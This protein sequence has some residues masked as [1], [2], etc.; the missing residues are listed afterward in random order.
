MIWI[1]AASL[2]ALMSVLW[3]VSYRKTN[4]GWVDIGWTIGTGGL[5]VLY[6]FLGD[7]D[8]LPRVAVGVLSGL[9]GLRLTV[10]DARAVWQCRCRS[11]CA[12]LS[13]EFCRPDAA[14]ARGGWAAQPVAP[15]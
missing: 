5:G 2:F 12:S 7:G 10:R 15:I 13:P 4:A 1:G 11:P 3:F 6:A 9:W 8:L 14:T